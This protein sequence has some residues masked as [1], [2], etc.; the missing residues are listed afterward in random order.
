VNWQ[1]VF[2]RPAEFLRA[3]LCMLEWVCHV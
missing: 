2:R 1:V 3:A